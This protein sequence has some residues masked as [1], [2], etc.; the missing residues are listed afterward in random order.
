MSA[1]CGQELTDTRENGLEG[2][3]QMK[4]MT[5]LTVYENNRHFC[6]LCHKGIM[7]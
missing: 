2:V 1:K 7:R 5:A 6:H 4:I 3:T